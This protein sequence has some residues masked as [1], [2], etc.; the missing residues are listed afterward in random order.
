MPINLQAKVRSRGLWYCIVAFLSTQALPLPFPLV[1]RSFLNF[2]K[3]RTT[4][5]NSQIFCPHGPSWKTAAIQ[6]ITNFEV[7]LVDAKLVMVSLNYNSW[8]L[9]NLMLFRSSHILLPHD[10]NTDTISADMRS[11]RSANMFKC[12][13]IYIFSIKFDMFFGRRTL[14]MCSSTHTCMNTLVRATKHIIDAG[15]T[16]RPFRNTLTYTYE[17]RSYADHR[18]ILNLTFSVHRPRPTKGGT[19]L[20]ARDSR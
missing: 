16:V 12:A 1:H 8:R 11:S 6:S 7:N 15:I 18:H 17:K 9:S 20:I 4:Y 19:T 3:R 13:T 2:D 5:Q 14:T 10:A